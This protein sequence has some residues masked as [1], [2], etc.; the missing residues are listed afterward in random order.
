[1]SDVEWRGMLQEKKSLNPDDKLYNNE[2]RPNEKPKKHAMMYSKT[3][4]RILRGIN[5]GKADCQEYFGSPENHRIF[6]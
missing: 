4:Q 1:M 6:C 3:L 5:Q 2:S